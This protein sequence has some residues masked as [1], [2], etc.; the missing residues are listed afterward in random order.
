MRRID[1][2][3]IKTVGNHPARRAEHVGIRE[4]L[5]PRP[6]L[7]V[8]LSGN[9]LDMSHV[10]AE[11]RNHLFIDFIRTAHNQRAH[12]QGTDIVHQPSLAAF[13]ASRHVNPISPERC[14]AL[15]V[16]SLAAELHAVMKC[17]P[18]L[19]HDFPECGEETQPTV[20][21]EVTGAG[22]TERDRQH[23]SGPLCVGES[24][25]SAAG[26]RPLDRHEVGP[27]HA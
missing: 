8:P 3:Q 2:H 7:L 14:A 27:D 15:S 1:A 4:G 9:P 17:D 20:S 5:V 21:N 26:A 13:H 6:E 25:T 18:G 11:E 16:R 23:E 12:E 10:T 24:A 19:G 22:E